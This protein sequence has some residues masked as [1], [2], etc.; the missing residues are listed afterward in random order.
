MSQTLALPWQFISPANYWYFSRAAG[1][2]A[3]VFIWSCVFT[4][5]LLKTKFVKKLGIAAEVNSAHNASARLGFYFVVFHI[6]VLY[7]DS[8][9]GSQVGQMLWPAMSHVENVGSVGLEIGKFALYAMVVLGVG[10]FTMRKHQAVVRLLHLLAY[11]AFF[12]AL[13][14][15]ILLGTDRNLAWLQML[16]W[17]TGSAVVIAV[18]LRA[19]TYF[20]QPLE[21]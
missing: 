17:F 21:A 5:I 13:G 3:Y 18:W 4:G 16:Y 1:I 7:F 20:A 8:T 6:T 14:H 12:L 10:F 9:V 19:M 11:P 15:G 2:V